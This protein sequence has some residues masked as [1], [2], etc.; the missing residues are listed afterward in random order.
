MWVRRSGGGPLTKET[1]MTSQTLFL[2]QTPFFEDYGPMKKAAGLYFP[3][4]LGYIAACAKAQGYDVRFFDPNV[5]HITPQDIARAAEEEHPI[6]VG[7]SFMTPQFFTAKRLC[8]TLKEVC[9]DIPVVLGGAHPSVM[10]ERTLREIPA[11]DFVAIGEAEETVVELLQALSTPR[12][13]FGGIAGLARRA[14]GRIV[15]NAAREPVDDLD[16]LPFP[17]RTLIDQ[18][19]YRPQSF[20]S[21]SRK[22]ATIYTSRG[23]P[24]RCVFCCSGHRLRSRVRQRSIE[25]SMAE[26]DHLVDRYGIDY[27]LVK[28]DTFT[29]KRAR[30]EAFCEALRGRHPGLKWHCMGRVDTVDRDLLARMQEAGLHH[31]FFGIESGNDE[32]LRRSR[33]GITTAQAWAAVKVCSQLGISTYG[34]FILGLPGETPQTAQDTISFACR[35]PLTMAGFSILIPYPG[36]Q[37]FEDHYQTDYDAPIDYRSFIAPTGIH[38]V[39]GYTGLEGLRVEELPGLVARAQRRFYLR[40]G[41]ILRLLRHATPSMLLGYGRG[42]LALVLKESYRIRQ[43]KV[44]AA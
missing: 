8:D 36:T 33:K 13:S 39:K 31:I 9:P 22:T 29:M 25:N 1:S 42:L 17:D 15:L 35:L 32:I 41:Q 16:A 3:L 44:L 19:L 27:L 5:Q 26:I 30:V 40:P 20:L 14:D 37:V 23:C 34:A 43:K 7:I 10:P 2:I 12:A 24:G 4:G 38:Y 18:S 6:L 21:Y 28:D 11:A